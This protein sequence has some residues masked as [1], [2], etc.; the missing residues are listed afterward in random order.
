MP[1]I[2]YATPAP[3]VYAETALVVEHIAPAPAVSCVALAPAVHAVPAPK[4]EHIAPAPVAEC[5]APAS[6][7]SYVTSAQAL[8][9]APAPVVVFITPA[10][11]WHSSL[12]V[13][14]TNVSHRVNRTSARRCLLRFGTTSSPWR[15][16]VGLGRTSARSIGKSMPNTA[17]KL[18]T[19][20]E[21]KYCNDLLEPKDCLYTAY[22]CIPTA[23]TVFMSANL[24]AARSSESYFDVVTSADIKGKNAWELTG[25]NKLLV[26]QGEVSQFTHQPCLIV[27]ADTSR[28][29]EAA[30]RRVAPTI[31]SSTEAPLVSLEAC[32]KLQASV[33]ASGEASAV[34]PCEHGDHHF[35]G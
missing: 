29:A 28:H 22:V 32:K 15:D 7:I 9:A 30:V 1:A 13:R 2:S 10:P 19:V 34:G 21:Q 26:P 27:L 6:A 24:S 20:G 12:C 16:E 8:Y 14:S 5:I 25:A 31:T 23:I 4:E 35:A 33:E 11:T 18:H 17:S 3:A